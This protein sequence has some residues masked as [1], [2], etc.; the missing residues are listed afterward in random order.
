VLVVDAG[1]IVERG[2][3]EELAARDGYFRKLSET[4]RGGIEI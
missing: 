1:R 3:P 4:Q 2:S